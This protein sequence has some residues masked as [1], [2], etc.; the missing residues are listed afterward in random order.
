MADKFDMQRRRDLADK[1]RALSF[2]L[3]GPEQLEQLRGSIVQIGMDALDALGAP[4]FAK[5]MLAG[6]ATSK[7]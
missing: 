4:G 1:L 6:Y 2:R 7:K 3:E 5:T